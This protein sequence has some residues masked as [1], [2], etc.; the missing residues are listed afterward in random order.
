MKK[1]QHK[2]KLRPVFM[3]I[4]DEHGKVIDRIPYTAADDDWLRARRLK[5]RADAGD[6]QA[7]AELKEMM[8]NQM[9]EVVFED[10]EE[11]GDG[12]GLRD[13][14]PDEDE[15]DEKGN[16]QGDAEDKET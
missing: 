10:E 12:E 14:N 9:M 16:K 1:K 8:N 15:E 11:E 7:A 6:E 4:T 2:L 5:L 13:G 3:E